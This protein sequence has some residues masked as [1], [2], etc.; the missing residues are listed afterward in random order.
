MQLEPANPSTIVNAQAGVTA[1][2]LAAG[3]SDRM[4]DQFKLIAPFR[5][6][7]IIRHVCEAVAASKATSVVVVTGHRADEVRQALDGIDVQITRNPEYSSGLSTSLRAGVR[8]LPAQTTACLVVLGDMPLIKPE[9]IDRL[10]QAFHDADGPVICV[11]MCD[12][13]RGN[14]VLWST[15]FFDALTRIEGDQGARSLI[16]ENSDSVVEVMVDDDGVLIDIDT[17]ETLEALRSL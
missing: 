11:P 8:A 14:P 10:I 3:Q 7:L 9:T 4:G 2:V 1:V 6:K 5:G 12:S 15:E 16:A 17:R 13:R